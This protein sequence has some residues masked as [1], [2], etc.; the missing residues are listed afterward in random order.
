MALKI[1]GQVWANKSIEIR[2]DNLVVVEVLSV[3]RARDN[4]MATCARNIWLLAAMYNINVIVMHI[5]GHDNC[6]R[7]IV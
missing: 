7:F 5:R 4:I 6:G 3:G 2:C 1:W